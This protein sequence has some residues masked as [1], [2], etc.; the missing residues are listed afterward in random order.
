ML[1]NSTE[2]EEVV[3]SITGTLPGDEEEVEEVSVFGPVYWVSLIFMAL[4]MTVIGILVFD[5]KRRAEENEQIKREA[6][7]AGERLVSV[8]DVLREEIEE[9][10]LLLSHKPNMTDN[11][12]QILEGLKNA[13]DISEELL[14]KE[15]EDVRKLV[16]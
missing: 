16:K 12:R 14:D 4:L 2:S 5:R 7:E 9:K 8:F 15:I 3:A 11:E 6:I 13:L 10:I 1:E